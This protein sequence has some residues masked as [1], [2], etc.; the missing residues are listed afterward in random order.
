MAIK[1]Q[2]LTSPRAGCSM[3]LVE[4]T[5][6][7]FVSRDARRALTQ[8]TFVPQHINGC[9]IC[10]PGGGS[11][12]DH[13]H[14]LLLKMPAGTF[15]VQVHQQV[16]EGRNREKNR[17]RRRGALMGNRNRITFCQVSTAYFR[18]DTC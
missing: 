17:H 7:L 4:H 14:R 6:A 13:M 8:I 10:G 18:P 2:I 11:L 16:C 15:G 5:H 9:S 3:D 12:A 1:E